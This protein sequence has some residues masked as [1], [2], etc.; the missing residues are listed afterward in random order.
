MLGGYSLRFVV[1]ALLAWSEFTF[2]NPTGAT[3]PGKI[4]ASVSYALSPLL[5]ALVIAGMWQVVD[6]KPGKPTFNRTLLVVWGIVLALLVL[7]HGAQVVTKVI[8][9]S[10]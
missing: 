10:R 5:I 7:S 6:R 3:L 4:T 1:T 9:G 2:G 8:E